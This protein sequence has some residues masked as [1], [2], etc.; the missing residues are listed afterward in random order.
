MAIQA[1]GRDRATEIRVGVTLVPRGE[2]PRVA[3]GIIAKRRLVE[4][5]LVLERKT[6]AH[7]ARPDEEAQI[8]VPAG[9]DQPEV[10]SDGVSPDLAGGLTRRTYQPGGIRHGCARISFH[11]LLV[12]IRA[13]QGS[14]KQQHPAPLEEHLQTELYVARRI[15]DTGDPAEV[16]R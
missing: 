5:L 10:G 9:P 16:A 6:T 2:I 1:I 4:V 13:H 14:S 15:C 12:A 3:V 11:Q 8:H 7:A